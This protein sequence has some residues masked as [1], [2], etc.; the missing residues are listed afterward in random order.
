[1]RKDPISVETQNATKALENIQADIQSET[2]I[3]E[4]LYV[5]K[6]VAQHDILIAEMQ[7]SSIAKFIEDENIRLTARLDEI[8]Q[9]EAQHSLNIEGFAK[10]LREIKEKIK[11]ETKNLNWII[12][13][14]LKEEQIL[15]TLELKRKD[16]EDLEKTIKLTIQ[17]RDE[18]ALELE[19]IEDS[20][21][22]YIKS[23]IEIMDKMITDLQ[24]VQKNIKGIEEETVLALQRRDR[25]IAEYSEALAQHRMAQVDFDIMEKRVEERYQLSFPGMDPR[26]VKK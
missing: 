23:H 6:K 9:R 7:K 2:K 3:L 13:K 16:L 26:K 25:A 21:S 14:V 11:T 15:A 1:M 5:Q 4:D 12:D 8:T 19:S 22:R 24:R 17:R 20:K 10:T 18:I